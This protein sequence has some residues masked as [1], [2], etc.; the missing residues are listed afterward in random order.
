M[1]CL[2]LAFALIVAGPVAPDDELPLS[3]E[4]DAVLVYEGQAAPV[5]VVVKI[6]DLPGLLQIRYRTV[7]PR[8]SAI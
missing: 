2:T 8:A 7:Y 1:R 6:R 4:R 3:F 5:D